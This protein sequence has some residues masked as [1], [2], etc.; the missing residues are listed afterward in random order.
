MD[1][2]EYRGSKSE[3]IREADILRMVPPGA[4]RSA[5]DVG[6][7]DGH[8]SK[9]LAQSFASVTALDLEK[10]KL[11]H[12]GVVCV[13][14]DVTS[15]AF[16]DSSFDFV[17]CAE[18]LEHIPP[19]S[20]ASAC[21]ELA[22]VTRGCLLVGVPFKQDTRIGRMTCTACGMRNPPW[23]HVNS[24]DE[25]KLLSLFSQLGVEAHSFVG[26]DSESTNGLSA[27]LM[28][29]AGNPYGTYGQDEPCIECGASLD[30]PPSRS[31]LQK[32]CTK[33]AFLTRRIT[34]PLHT[35]HPYW[36]HY[37]FHKR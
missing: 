4:G 35:P 3:A 2:K 37:L 11:L 27:L 10:P 30:A 32:A 18:V 15:L 17:L 20:L 36:M 34:E 8:F 9:I 1:L 33:A 19:Q 22:R 16:P 25:D 23:G 13:R 6:A 29:L 7:R 26:I 24:F 21:S 5:L 14:G 12:P 28:D 31:L